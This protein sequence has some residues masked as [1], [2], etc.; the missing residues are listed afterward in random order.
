[1]RELDVP[2]H[3][4]TRARA[5]RGRLRILGESRE[6]LPD[7]VV[8]SLVRRSWPGNVRELRNFVERSACLGWP[9]APSERV[10]PSSRATALPPG[11]ET[12]VPMHLPFKEAR[13][14][15]MESFETVY[16]GAL[17]R[18]TGG[19]VTRAAELAGLHRRTLQRILASL[20]IRTND[21]SG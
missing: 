5:T 14:A 10:S 20:G 17:L 15:W 9:S 11:L 16:L 18:K 12:L 8:A 7:A 13:V 2:R 21:P 4:M 1:M 6:P 19:N 3:D